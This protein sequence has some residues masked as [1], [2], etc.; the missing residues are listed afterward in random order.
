MV[1]LEKFRIRL[2]RASLRSGGL[3][4]KF[5]STVRLYIS[6]CRARHSSAEV[7][8]Q[9]FLCGAAW[10]KGGLLNCSTC[11]LWRGANQLRSAALFHLFCAAR[12][13]VCCTGTAQR[14][15]M[16][17]VKNYPLHALQDLSD[18]GVLSTIYQQLGWPD[19]RI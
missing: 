8:C 4:D 11:F 6:D 7:C 2:R 1:E 3:L 13:E 19:A 9:P 16:G 12:L 14:D 17:W 10:L 18:D 15:R 5:G